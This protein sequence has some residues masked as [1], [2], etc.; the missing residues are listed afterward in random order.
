MLYRL[1]DVGVSFAGRAILRGISFQHNPGEKIVLL[2]RNGSGK[3]TLLRVVSGEL[4][5]EEGRVTPASALS[6]ARLEQI[7][8]ADPRSTVLDHCLSAFPRFLAIE[9]ELAEAGDTLSR[10]GEAALARFHEL[11]EAYERMDGYR[12]RPRAQASLQAV[13]LAAEKHGRTLGSLSGGQR[14]RVALVR[15]LLSPAELLLLDE[16]TNHLDLLGVEFLAT[17]LASREGAF[18]LVTHDRDLV[19]RVGGAII[20]LH[21]GRLERYPGGFERYRRERA[22]RRA[23]QRKEWEQQQEEIQRQEEFIRRNIAGQN[24][25]QAQARQKLLDKIVRLEPPEPDPGPLRLR[26]P[27]RSR[28]GD[29]V[30][31]VEGLE[32]GWDRP[33]LRGVGLLLRRGDRLAVVGRNGAGKSTLMKTLAGRIPQ[34]RGG[35]RLGTGVVAA[36]Y[37]QE[38]AE[39]PGGQSVLGC[40][41]ASR[42]DWAPAEARSW[43]GRFGFSGDAA[44]ADTGTLSGGERARLALARLIAE[45]PNLLLL[46]EPTNHLDIAT[47][48]VLENALAEFPGAV[49]VVSHD[50]RLVERVCTGV[51]LIAEGTAT[52]VDRVSE[53]FARIGMAAPVPREREEETRPARRSPVEEERRRLRRDSARARE[54]ADGLAAELDGAERRGRELDELLCRREVFSDPGQARTLAA[55]ADEVKE[56]VEELFERWSEEEEEAAAL[57]ARLAELESA[58]A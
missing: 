19:D 17:E 36:W 21:G 44:E 20:E 15:A 46:D 58:E 40:L 3:T 27:E 43:A 11:Q 50:R 16:P 39:L 47:C 49:L 34:L 9:A 26:W 12:L 33:L 4:E 29:R 42:P 57:E 35:I 30:L 55:E 53:A 18:L 22:Q 6:V 28:S 32:V 52:V 24:T 38:E 37:D 48:E 8:T 23:R 10:G 1:D 45:A 51:L 31:E 56:L 54:R 5:P 2:G 7:L 14:T 13:G 41:L 25:R